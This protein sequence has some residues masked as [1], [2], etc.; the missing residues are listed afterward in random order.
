M[1]KDVVK[2]TSTGL[3]KYS[4]EEFI[5]R[6]APKKC[7]VELYK[8]NTVELAVKS[9]LKSL[10]KLS[11]VFDRE[12]IV[13][14]LQLWIIDLNE[15]LNLSTRMSP[16]QIKD[17]AELLYLANYTLNIADINLIFTNIKSGKYGQLF[18]SIDGSKILSWF[19]EYKGKRTE[20]YFE[21][22]SMHEHEGIKKHGWVKWQELNGRGTSATLSDHTSA[23]LSQQDATT[24]NKEAE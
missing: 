4:K 5:K 6:F 17:T 2:K 8:V 11:K 19:N 3:V 10:A 7:M 1:S 9:G 16:D 14:Y 13:N 21:N 18:G 20:W 24:D 22:V 12:F 15:F 23:T